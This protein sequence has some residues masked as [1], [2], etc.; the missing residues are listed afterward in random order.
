[1]R[2]AAILRSDAG[3]R[4]FRGMS[5]SRKEVP[6]FQAPPAPSETGKRPA[7]RGPET[8]ALVLVV[9][10]NEDARDLYEEF[11]V[12]SGLR[13]ATAVDGRHGLFKVAALGPDVV[14]MDLSMPV[15][16]GC[17]ATKTMKAHPD[18]Q[19]IPVVVLTGSA[20]AE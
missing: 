5:G 13:V 9:D 8:A 18:H 11:F 15:L 4:C 16:D 14:I 17:E 7:I 12:C 2:H 1:M 6:R 19:N 20:D 10:D 3:L